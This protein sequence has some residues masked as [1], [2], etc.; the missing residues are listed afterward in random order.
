VF[1]HSFVSRLVTQMYF[2]GDRPFPLDGW[3]ACSGRERPGSDIR[4]HLMLQ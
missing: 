3:I 4:Q 2:P 1:G